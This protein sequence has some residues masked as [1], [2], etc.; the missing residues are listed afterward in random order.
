[1]WGTERTMTDRC[2]DDVSD[3]HTANGENIQLDLE[4][5]ELTFF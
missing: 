4:A 2:A 5:H 3:Q 1:M